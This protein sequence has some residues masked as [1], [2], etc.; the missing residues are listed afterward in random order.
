MNRRS[1][2]VIAIIWLAAGVFNLLA[3]HNTGSRTS[4]IFTVL[5]FALFALYLYMGLKN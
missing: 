1:R 5:D 4:L 2:I 3:Y